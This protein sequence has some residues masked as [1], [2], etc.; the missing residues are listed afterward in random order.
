M[1]WL[2]AKKQSPNMRPRIDWLR[3]FAPF[4]PFWIILAVIAVA[5]HPL[6]SP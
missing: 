1:N 2:I 5:L 4:I 3:S 6:F